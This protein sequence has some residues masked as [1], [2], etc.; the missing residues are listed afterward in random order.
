MI[1]FIILSIIAVMLLIGAVTILSI[2]GAFAIGI[3]AD[4][5]VCIGLIVLLI[6]FLANRKK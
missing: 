2:G 1:L 4:L 6:K 5:I 3:F